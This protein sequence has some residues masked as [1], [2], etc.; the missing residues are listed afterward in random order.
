MARVTNSGGQLCSLL[1]TDLKEKPAPSTYCMCPHGILLGARS[2]IACAT[3]RLLLV[4]ISL[5]ANHY[6]FGVGF[7]TRTLDAVADVIYFKSMGY[8]SAYRA[9]LSCA[10][11]AD[12]TAH[13]DEKEPGNQNIAT[14]SCL[15]VRWLDRGGCGVDSRFLSIDVAQKHSTFK[16]CVLSFQRNRTATHIAQKSHSASF[17]GA[18]VLCIE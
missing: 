10:F 1:K 14:Q 7:T 15:L 9:I 18:L 3:G 5:S 17:L 2:R 12:A 8:S 16:L 4:G 11:A 13:P 6:L